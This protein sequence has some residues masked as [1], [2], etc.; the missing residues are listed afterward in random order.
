[1]KSPY[2]HQSDCVRSYG[3]HRQALLNEVVEAAVEQENLENRLCSRCTTERCSLV[4]IH[5]TLKT[6]LYTKHL[7]KTE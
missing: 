3:V 4:S 1:M 6:K 5:P 2:H 7:T